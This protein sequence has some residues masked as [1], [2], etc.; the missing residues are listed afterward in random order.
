MALGI[1][2]TNGG[3][4]ESKNVLLLYRRDP[5]SRDF[6]DFRGCGRRRGEPLKLL[7]FPVLVAK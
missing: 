4:L 1:P 6:S 7:F 5:H 2:L 3:S